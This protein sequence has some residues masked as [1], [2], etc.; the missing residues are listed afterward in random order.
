[1]FFPHGRQYR[2]HVIDRVDLVF[3]D[4][5]LDGLALRHVDEFEG[6]RFEKML[7]RLGFVPGGDHI[8]CAILLSQRKRQLR[9]DL[10]D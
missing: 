4:N 9:P 8:V 6:S 3:L 2:R 1:M 10:A 7:A 5:S